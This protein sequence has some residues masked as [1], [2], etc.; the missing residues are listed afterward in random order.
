MAPNQLQG[1]LKMW[2]CAHEKEKEVEFDEYVALSLPQ[3]SLYSFFHADLKTATQ[4]RDFHY[5]H[6]RARG[7][8]VPSPSMP[9][10]S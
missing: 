2:S 3:Q 9:F 6:L 1:R 10:K 4:V 5:S 7:T 8:H